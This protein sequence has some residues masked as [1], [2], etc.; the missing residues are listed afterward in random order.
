MP[1]ALITEP[2][3]GSFAGLLPAG[4]PLAALAGAAG[5]RPSDAREPA[6]VVVEGVRAGPVDPLPSAVPDVAAVGVA[7]AAAGV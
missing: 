6:V 2:L 7:E 4:L 5:A 3:E 1:L